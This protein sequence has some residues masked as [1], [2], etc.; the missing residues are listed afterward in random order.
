MTQEQTEK[1]K[2]SGSF[3]RELPVLL[4]VAL[5][6]AFGVRQFV[7]QTFYIPSES[8]EHTL[9]RYDRV[10]VNKLVYEFRAPEEGEIIVFESPESWRNSME[11]KDFIKRVIGA[12]GDH[13]VCCDPQGR[14]EVNGH[15]LDEPYVYPGNKMAP[16]AFDITV[17]AGRLWVM[18]DHRE[19]SS[20]SL[21]N[22]NSHGHDLQ[23]ATIPVDAVI[24]RAFVLFWPFDRS[25]WLTRPET[26]DG[27]PH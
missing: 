1:R 5:V 12:A 22:Y 9:D 4:V 3:W 26:F 20:D 10:L 7:V 23:Q 15:A 6:V 14:I 2:K 18:G 16:S 11:E 24:G 25:T 21:A 27:I 8:M 13:V 19:A 17:P